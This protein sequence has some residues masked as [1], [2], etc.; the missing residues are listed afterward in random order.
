M[1]INKR[2]INTVE[3]SKGYIIKNV[4]YQWIA[5]LAN[6]IAVFNIG[7][8]IQ[9]VGSGRVMI[10]ELVC[11]LA[12]VLL[13]I[14]IRYFCNIK[15]GK[16]SYKASAKVKTTLRELI[17]KKLLALGNGYKERV[18]TSEI[19]QV[20]VEGVE[21]LEVY[22][23]RYLPQFFYSL[24][25][26]I[27]LF[28][29]LSFIN[30]KAA[31]VLLACVP[32]IPVSI[33][34]IQKLAKKL[35]S[36]YWT[37]YTGLGD[38]FLENVQGMTTLKIFQADEAKN[39]EMNEEAELFRKI[40]MKVLTMQ[41]NS[42]TI[43][44][45]I[46]FGGAALGAILAITE[47]QKGNIALWQGFVIIMLSAE[48]FI[49]LRLLGSF[50]HIA[51]NGMAASDKL[52]K[53]LDM[54]KEA[55]DDYQEEGFAAPGD[56]LF[57]NDL[58]FSYD[59]EREILKKVNIDIPKG[60]F[61]ALVG[62][63]GCGKSTAASLAMGFRKNYQGF[64]SLD[65]ESIKNINEEELMKKVTYLNHN[66]YIFK[67]TVRENLLVGNKKATDQDI[68]SVLKQ[69]NLYDF[70]M[71][72]GGLDMMIMEK[73]GNLS[74]GQAQ[75]LALARALLHNSEMYIFDEATSNI[76]VE[77]EE[78]IMTAIK[79]MAKD[80][81]ILLISHRLAQVV[82]ADKIYLL[83]DGRVREEGTH[84]ELM[85]KKGQYSRLFLKQQELESYGREE[86]VING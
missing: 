28:V 40:T 83:E 75:R 29:V 71:E 84:R 27:T 57:F 17:Y 7:L 5:L 37:I 24:L 64:I 59:N 32:L 48:F 85:N 81:T 63:S 79:E 22:F 44:D 39:K 70:I 1:M 72:N 38:S 14:G 23:G 9:R 74:G 52:F 34:A 77:S 13:M 46:A 11:V 6:I 35:L 62:K 45:L 2:L 73:A 54:E 30:I 55:V 76:D 60:S 25:A 66:S 4:A 58:T 10:I 18:S 69:V 16:M 49:P 51:M 56:G 31:A 41:L 3:E 65:G 50:F 12:I 8:L 78:A 47:Y 42:V 19:V 26:P 21:Q 15:A 36:K 82:D 68:K 43:M 67:G 61:V 53:L 80:K 20:S 86:S 33:I